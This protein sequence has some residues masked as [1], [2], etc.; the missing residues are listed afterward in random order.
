MC[1]S[2]TLGDIGG[3]VVVPGTNTSVSIN[4]TNASGPVVV[5]VI[6]WTGGSFPGASGTEILHGTVV[7]TLLTNAGESAVDVKFSDAGGSPT[8]CAAYDEVTRTWDTT[9][10]ALGTD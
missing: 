1:C 5:Q 6:T 10:C 8:G 2:E 9:K 3:V 4:I 7:T